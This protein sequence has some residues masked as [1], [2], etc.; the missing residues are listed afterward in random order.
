MYRI[1]PF[2]GNL[3]ETVY[4]LHDEIEGFLYFIM[5]NDDK[6]EKV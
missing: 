4:F 5:R 1:L 2:Y 6:I 3:S